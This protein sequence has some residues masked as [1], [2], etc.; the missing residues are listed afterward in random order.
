MYLTDAIKDIDKFV[1]DHLGH[2]YE[3]SHLFMSSNIFIEFTS[4]V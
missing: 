4:M 1:S 2:I 3:A